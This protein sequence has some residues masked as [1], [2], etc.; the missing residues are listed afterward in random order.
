M[1]GL[2]KETKGG[3]VCRGG[4]VGT[5]RGPA[6]LGRPCLWPSGLPGCSGRRGRSLRPV[7]EGGGAPG[8]RNELEPGSRPRMLGGRTGSFGPPRV[9]A[10]AGSF[11]RSLAPGPSTRHILPGSS[12]QL[13]QLAQALPRWL[14]TCSARPPVAEYGAAT[15]VTLAILVK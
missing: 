6:P 4:A 15:K 11:S 9:L 14:P 10:P 1:E 3:D 7:W 8:P 5:V 13:L 12:F 2:I